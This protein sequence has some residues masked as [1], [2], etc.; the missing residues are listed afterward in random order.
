MFNRLEMLQKECISVADKLATDATLRIAIRCYKSDI[1]IN[2]V[3]LHFSP[4]FDISP[5]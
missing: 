5:H 3:T 4:M 2:E 1:S